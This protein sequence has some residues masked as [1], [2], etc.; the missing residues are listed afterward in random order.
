M[1]SA[2]DA[3]KPADNVAAAKADLRA[4]LASAKAE[5]EALQAITANITPYSFSGNRNRLLNGSA[6]VCQRTG[7]GFASVAGSAVFGPDR[8]YIS[9]AQAGAALTLSQQLSPGLAQYPNALQV[10][11]ATSK[12]VVAADSHY[13]SLIHI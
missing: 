5:I 13:L 7:S 12:T 3:T 10:V 8:W 9:Q 4:N 2:I 6:Q 1:A 11:V